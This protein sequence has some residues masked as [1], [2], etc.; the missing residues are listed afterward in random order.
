VLGP[1]LEEA[2][3]E[4]LGAEFDDTLSLR[5]ELGNSLG[6]FSPTDVGERLG[7]DLGELLI[8]ALG[9]DLVTVTQSDGNGYLFL[10]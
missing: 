4:A 2:L 3:E 10:I 5:N 8:E 9:P 1:V 7:L 6:A